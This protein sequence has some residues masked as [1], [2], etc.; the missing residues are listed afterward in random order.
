[1]DSGVFR[2]RV[3]HYRIIW[4]LM[5][6]GDDFVGSNAWLRGV[7]KLCKDLREPICDRDKTVTKPPYLNRL[8]LALSEKQSP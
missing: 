7:S 4:A 5:N 1:M 8:G 3:G 6:V 2:Y